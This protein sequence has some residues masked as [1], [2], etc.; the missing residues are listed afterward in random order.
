LDRQRTRILFFL[1]SDTLSKNLETGATKRRVDCWPFFTHQRDFNGNTRLQVLAILEPYAPGSHKVERDY[2][3][4]WSFWR[5]EQNPRTGAASQSLLWNLY[6][7]ET[8]KTDKKTSICF[9]LFQ[10]QS[11]AEGRQM[12]L[13]YVPIGSKKNKNA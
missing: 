1:Y 12:K 4:L 5:A 11:N 9:G 13:F 2:S 10:Y 6:R 3:Q 7:H 8:T